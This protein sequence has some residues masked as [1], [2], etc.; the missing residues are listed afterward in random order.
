MGVFFSDHYGEVI[1]VQQV[2]RHVRVQSNSLQFHD[3]DLFVSLLG[4]QPTSFAPIPPLSGG[5][6]Q[7]GFLANQLTLHQLFS[8]HVEFVEG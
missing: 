4:A 6:H 8:W 2:M 7:T 3:S 5:V 1:G